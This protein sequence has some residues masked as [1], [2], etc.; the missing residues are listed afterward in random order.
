MLKIALMFLLL[1]ACA[2]SDA[3]NSPTTNRNRLA[4]VEASYGAAQSVALAYINR[5]PCSR[6]PVATVCSDPST[7]RT[8][9]AADR[10]AIREINMAHAAVKAGPSDPN[11][12]RTIVGAE[13][14]VENFKNVTPK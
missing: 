8:I 11:N 5:P 4:T 12:T 13:R 1:G 3:S 9:Q 7:V 2:S 6:Q 14:A 10:A